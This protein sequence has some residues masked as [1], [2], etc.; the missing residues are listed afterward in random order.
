MPTLADQTRESRNEY[1][2][3]NHV[4]SK[5]MA[6]SEIREESYRGE[7]SNKGAEELKM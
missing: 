4:Y 7:D 3:P 2:V 5:V 6:D 1:N